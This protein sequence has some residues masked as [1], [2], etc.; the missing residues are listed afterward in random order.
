M[1][2]AAAR[3]VVGGLP[4]VVSGWLDTRYRQARRM[5]SGPMTVGENADTGAN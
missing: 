3:D 2:A 4:M 5:S 1:R